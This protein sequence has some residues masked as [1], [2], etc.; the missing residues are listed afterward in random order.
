MFI[1]PRLSVPSR[2]GQDKD[3][4]SPLLASLPCTKSPGFTF[5]CKV[6]VE[7]SV[8][9]AFESGIRPEIEHEIEFQRKSRIGDD[10]FLAM[11][12]AKLG[13]RLVQVRPRLLL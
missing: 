1:L 2:Y 8:K 6:K 5:P 4:S 12:E 11:T 13:N 10:N 3:S 9:T 7:S